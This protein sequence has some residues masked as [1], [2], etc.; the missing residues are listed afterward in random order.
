MDGRKRGRTVDNMPSTKRAEDDK[1]EVQDLLYHQ[2]KVSHTRQDI[3][4]WPV[5]DRSSVDDRLPFNRLM[6]LWTHLAREHS[7]RDLDCILA[8]QMRQGLM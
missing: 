3:C 8:Q 1:V 2:N 5:A 6:F 7:P 4:V